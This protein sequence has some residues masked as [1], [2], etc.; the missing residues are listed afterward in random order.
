M[1]RRGQKATLGRKERK[2]RR[3]LL[4]SK[5]PSVNQVRLDQ[6]A[7]LV[8]TVPLDR[9]VPSDRLDQKVH[10]AKLDREGQ[11]D[12]LVSR[13]L[14][15]CPDRTEPQDRRVF[16]ETKVLSATSDRMVKQVS[17]GS[18]ERPGYEALMDRLDH[19]ASRVFLASRV[20]EVNLVNK[21]YLGRRDRKANRD[22]LGHK[23]LAVNLAY[24]AY[25]ESPDV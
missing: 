24:R 18:L 8:L 23:D 11:L 3:V 16:V 21:V 25:P 12:S 1:V 13:V 17:K 20:L 9:W 22:Y 15:E 6:M 4:V 10:W 2:D 14:M 5:G 7:R 19:E